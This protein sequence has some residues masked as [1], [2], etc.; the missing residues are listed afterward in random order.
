MDDIDIC[1]PWW[2]RIIWWLIH[3]PPRGPGPRPPSATKAVTEATESLLVALHSYHG[4]LAI[5]PKQEDL[6]IQVQR[7]AIE[8]MNEGLAAVG[9]TCEGLGVRC[10]EGRCGRPAC[11]AGA[12]PERRLTA[13]RVPSRPTLSE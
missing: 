3:H 11:A 13:A 7:A 8:Q 2:P 4:A 5:G 1:P 12:T 6:R 10:G 9:T